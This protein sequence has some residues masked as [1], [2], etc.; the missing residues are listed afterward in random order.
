MIAGG[1]PRSA[2][3]LPNLPSPLFRLRTVRP[4]T[5]R[6]L[7][8]PA[9]V[10]PLHA[11]E[12]PDHPLPT[13]ASGQND[14]VSLRRTLTC[15]FHS[16][17]ASTL[18]LNGGRVCART[19]RI[20]SLRPRPA[21]A[22]STRPTGP[23]LLPGIRGQRRQETLFAER[24]PAQSRHLPDPGSGSGWPALPIRKLSQRP[25]A[26]TREPAC[27]KRHERQKTE[28]RT[29]AAWGVDIAR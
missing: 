13:S 25:C 4:R 29:E 28:Q 9:P 16:C 22:S 5:S 10:T 17:Q 11:C 23:Q 8:S 6:R 15:R 1:I 14:C 19:W 12:E 18:S 7:Q 21:P 20:P 2:P 24:T 3:L 26:G 27:E